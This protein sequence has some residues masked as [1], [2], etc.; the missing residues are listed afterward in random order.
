MVQ[1]GSPDLKTAILEAVG[2]L[3]I[4]SYLCPL[5]SYRLTAL[6]PPF[7]TQLYD[8]FGWAL[9]K[10]RVALPVAPY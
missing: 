7:H 3:R 10:A 1:E 2:G 4:S 5:L 8:D 6:H 9:F